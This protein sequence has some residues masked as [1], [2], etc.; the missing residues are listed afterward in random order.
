MA[1]IKRGSTI[2][3]LLALGVLAMP[4]WAGASTVQV[5]GAG[6]LR[7][8]GAA[9]ESNR[10]QVFYKT[11][12]EAGFDGVSDRFVVEDSGATPTSGSD[13]CV[14]F[15]QD[16]V[17]CDARPVS[18]VTAFLGGGDDIFLMNRVRKGSPKS[19][20][21]IVVHGGPGNDVIRG[22]DGVD[23]LFGEGGRDVL[24]GALGNDVLS[25]G[26]DSDAVIGFGGNDLLNGGPG[27]DA[28]FGQRGHDVL[29]GGSGLD[30]LL[31][32]DGIHDRRI[33]CGG[34]GGRALLDNRD[35]KAHG[36]KKAPR[37]GK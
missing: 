35:P 37:K 14:V 10:I 2:A 22:G 32:R 19:R 17:T 28:V 26:P 20:V 7:I 23:R 18:S 27:P 29:L 1:P 6:E 13:N 24:S 16:K 30:V 11:A 12:A 31:A 21:K 33:N 15:D 8:D 3:A 34:G 5:T 36:C 25:G 9:G 4:N